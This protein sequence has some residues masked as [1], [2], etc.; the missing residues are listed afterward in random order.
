MKN[1]IYIL[2]LVFVSLQIQAQETAVMFKPDTTGFVIGDQ[3]NVLLQAEAPKDSIIVWPILPDTIGKLE[4]VSRSSIDTL[5]KDNFQIISQNYKLTQFDSGSYVLNPVRFRIGDKVMYTKPKMLNVSTVAVDTTKQKIFG[6][7]GNIHVGYTF[8]EILPYIL[9][10]LIV[11]AML[12]L[13]Y[14]F[15]KKHKPKERKVFIPQIPPYD[16][17]M[18]HLKKLDEARLIKDGNVKEYYVRLTDI[19]RRYIEDEFH[20]PAMESTTLEIM[21][22]IRDNEIGKEAKE[23]IEELLKESDFVKFAKYTPSAGKHPY[24]RKTTEEIIVESHSLIS[25]DIDEKLETSKDE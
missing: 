22:S 20:I 25:S 10:F 1:I 24:F 12:L 14:Y 18:Q 21:D 19:L 13:A 16:L 6:I 4:V 8:W 2:T 9:L 15:W 23:K 5:F 7:K 11:V 3:I 17:A